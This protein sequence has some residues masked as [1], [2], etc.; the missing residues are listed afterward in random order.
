M[1][2]SHSF[3]SKADTGIPAGNAD[4]NAGAT[5]TGVVAG[6]LEPPE[7]PQT[8]ESAVIGSTGIRAPSS[9]QL[10]AA[11]GVQVHPPNTNNCGDVC[12][13]LPF[14]STTSE[15]EQTRI[16]GDLAKLRSRMDQKVPGGVDENLFTLVPGSQVSGSRVLV[17]C[18]VCD[19]KIQSTLEKTSGRMIFSAFLKHAGNREHQRKRVANKSD[20]SQ[21]SASS[22]SSSTAASS[23]SSPSLSSSSVDDGLQQVR[24][25]QLLN[26]SDKNRIIADAKA[27]LDEGEYTVLV[28]ANGGGGGGSIG[29]GGGGGGGGGDGGQSDHLSVEIK[30]KCIRCQKD[31]ATL[32]KET[33]G[34]NMFHPFMKHC[35]TQSHQQNGTATVAWSS[36]AKV[37]HPRPKEG[38]QYDIAPSKPLHTASMA[39]MASSSLES[40]RAPTTR[41]HQVHGSFP[42]KLRL[43]RRDA[44]KAECIK[45]RHTFPLYL[46]NKNL[47]ENIRLHLDGGQCKQVPQKMTD[48]FP[49]AAAVN[50]KAGTTTNN[51]PRI[52]T[53]ATVC[54]GYAATS[55]TYGD[56]TYGTSALL[57]RNR[58]TH[59]YAVPHKRVQ[60]P[61]CPDRKGTFFH[62][63]CDIVAQ[64]VYGQ[65]VP[66]RC[67]AKCRSIPNDTQFRTRLQTLAQENPGKTSNIQTLS[68]RELQ[69]RC[70]MESQ[71]K[72]K[73][74]LTSLTHKRSMDRQ[75][76]RTA[77]ESIE[78]GMR[79]G[80]TSQM[81]RDIK[82]LSENGGFEEQRV[83]LNFLCDEVKMARRKQEGKDARG[84]RWH[85]T[86]H[87]LFDIIRLQAGPRI[88]ALLRANLGAASDS[89]TSRH[90]KRGAVVFEVQSVSDGNI[91]RALD[92]YTNQLQ[93]LGIDEDEVI[94]FEWSEDETG[95]IPQIDML[96]GH[97]ELVGTCGLKCEQHQCDM[98]YRVVV[99]NEDNSYDKIVNT[100]C[101]C[102]V[103]T[104]A[105]VIMI[106]PLRDDLPA[107]AMTAMS[108]CNRFNADEVRRQWNACAQRIEG[109]GSRFMATGHAS[110]GD[111]RR[112]KLQFKDMTK[113]RPDP[114][115]G[116]EP[117][118]GD[119]YR[120]SCPG[121]THSG[122]YTYY[123]DGDN[124]PVLRVK[125]IHSQ[126]V[127]HNMKKH[128]CVLKSKRVL[129]LGEHVA[130]MSHLKQVFET[131]E[132]SEHG[133]QLDDVY[134]KDRQNVAAAGRACGIKAIG[135]LE[136]LAEG[137]TV[138]KDGRVN[139]PEDTQG[140][141]AL[142][143][144][145]QRYARI[146]F[147]EKDTLLE[148]V[149]SASFVIHF[150]LFQ[151]AYV[152]T[153]PGLTIKDNFHTRQTY[154]HTVL[155]CFSAI[156]LI[157]ATRDFSSSSP[158]GLSKTGSDCLERLFA[159]CG[160]F[161]A[162]ASWQ[163][164]YS[165]MKMVSMI[166]KE[167][168]IASYG[169]G[170][171]S[172]GLARRSHHKQEVDP[173]LLDKA[174]KM[175]ADLSNYSDD[176]AME[177]R[178]KAGEDEARAM[179]KQLGMR[180]TDERLWNEPWLHEES[181]AAKMDNR[182]GEEL[183]GLDELDD[184]EE[185]SEN[186]VRGKASQALA[187][188]KLKVV[189]LRNELS[190]R[191]LDTSGLKAAL[192]SR[193]TAAIESEKET[194]E[195]AAGKPQETAV[196][197]S[198][199]DGEETK[200]VGKDADDGLDCIEVDKMKVSMV[201]T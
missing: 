182:E 145:N 154:Q 124:E 201:D 119:A 134:K 168:Q 34:R 53:P 2:S 60:L 161:G 95:V 48:H 56:T 133:L 156:L 116:E 91:Q 128:I 37:G 195:K 6:I 19:C 55:V 28:C 73:G 173:R 29:A 183:D 109:K 125:G 81:L 83:L 86:T 50:L 126:D 176:A 68:K 35:T 153:A 96:P 179:A 159:N 97:D 46:E 42:G 84:N 71:E 162:I 63:N 106:N 67:C 102:T 54:Q 10:A 98:E 16:Q 165:F 115:Q 129:R 163:R 104:Y 121:F 61:D 186:V 40:A 92:M 80:D 12:E 21:H 8:T 52:H 178:F 20:S 164:N 150:L 169:N 70:R 26:D 189:Q 22:P 149:Q 191:G 105:R 184:N 78:D 25:S 136:K 171:H 180:T 64:D 43:L 85:E 143:T 194:R 152:H 5:D 123:K 7:L 69:E 13:T 172:V 62:E 114:V 14:I 27:I 4:S 103:A 99:G 198:G 160:G 166:E 141:V 11:G 49:D 72:S 181:L 75:K 51:L 137:P 17:H 131:F 155:S 167:S 93:E 65:P 94:L 32:F 33:G 77:K 200:D 44:S 89:V 90:C 100:F 148:R 174:E 110:D 135:C 199:N 88:N 39:A 192:A 107:L 117:K 151:A 111:A 23:S 158:C 139:G 76:R 66:S 36:S 108:T 144:M 138:T 79:R 127:K 9:T 196:Y 82:W 142:L 187:V 59:W 120:L 170:C 193:L 122:E 30:I 113:H 24:D 45:C 38:V 146:F 185:G 112:F 15:E 197:D 175:D 140:T 132:P 188:K 18:L 87:R 58:G 101:K 3:P 157:R 41:M 31:S 130:C 47:I 57:D 74:R 190:D 147:S 1:Y 118:E 177:V